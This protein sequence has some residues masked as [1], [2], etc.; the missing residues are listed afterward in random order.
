MLQQS[1]ELYFFVLAE[2]GYHLFFIFF[3][4]AVDSF[5]VVVTFWQ[6]VNAF[7]PAV[8]GVGTQFNKAF[9]FKAAEESRNSGMTQLKGFFNILGAGWIFPVRKKTHDMSL[10]SRQIHLRQCAGDR[11][12]ELP[13]EDTKLVAIVVRQSVHPFW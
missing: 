5:E 6:Y 7:A 3:D 12:I 13:V 9:P 4:D 1:S 11:L 8:S 2:T 10:R